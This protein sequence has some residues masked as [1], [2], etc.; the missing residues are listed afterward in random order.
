MA[1]MLDTNICIYVIKKKPDSVLR[2]LHRH[3][4]DDLTISSITLSELEYGVAKSSRPEENHLALIRFL[5]ILTT[6]P[7]DD[8][9]AQS[10]GVLRAILE[11]E[12]KTIGPL[13]MLIAAHAL[14]LGMTLVTNN[15]KEFSRVRGLETVNWAAGTS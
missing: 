15:T 2:K 12:G 11:K 9:A 6:L 4:H 5:M 1:F 10:Y 7:Y 3:L 13:D 8:A 14:S